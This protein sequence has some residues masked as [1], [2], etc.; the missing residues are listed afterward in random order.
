[1]RTQG[2]EGG[3]DIVLDHGRRVIHLQPLYQP[4]Q[5]K[6]L[7][8]RRQAEEGH[9]IGRILSVWGKQCAGEGAEEGGEED[10]GEL[11]SDIGLS[12]GATMEKRGGELHVGDGVDPVLP[13]PVLM[14]EDEEKKHVR[15][16][17]GMTSP[18]LYLAM[19]RSKMAS[20]S[21]SVF[22]RQKM[23]RESQRIVS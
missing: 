5:I 23:L 8:G 3:G 17:T 2:N 1:M 14:R 19:R 20:I 22:S 15:Q 7:P 11:R 12:E 6:R 21:G 10:A 4:L 16:R 13:S 18:F 9:R